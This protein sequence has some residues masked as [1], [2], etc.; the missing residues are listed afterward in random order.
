MSGYTVVNDITRKST[1]KKDKSV[2][3]FMFDEAEVTPLDADEMGY[4]N[5]LK[6]CKECMCCCVCKVVAEADLSLG[7]DFLG[8]NAGKM[9]MCVVAAASTASSAVAAA[10]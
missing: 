6:V 7:D 10:L 8:L 4:M 9:T 2:K 3:V 1:V 5:V